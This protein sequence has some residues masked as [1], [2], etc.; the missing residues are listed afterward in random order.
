MFWYLQDNLRKLFIGGL[1]RSTT[2]D[3]VKEMM[4]QFGS[5]NDVVVIRDPTTQQSRGFGFVTYDTEK[6]TDDAL[7]YRREN[8]PFTI[9]GKNVEVKR[10]IPRDVS[11]LF[12]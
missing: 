1:N 3:E 9:K 6:S 4:G 11:I 7:Q 2:D 10:A 12:S 8:G 5:M